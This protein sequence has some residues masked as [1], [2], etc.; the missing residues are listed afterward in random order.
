MGS[1]VR[2]WPLSTLSLP[3]FSPALPSE[4][5]LKSAKAGKHN[6]KNQQLTCGRIKRFDFGTDKSEGI[7]TKLYRLRGLGKARFGNYQTLPSTS[8]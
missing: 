8:L 1:A 3:F 4:K 5:Y 6:F 2:S 7:T